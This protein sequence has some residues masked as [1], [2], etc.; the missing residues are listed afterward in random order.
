MVLA[1]LVALLV[2]T[3]VVITRNDLIFGGVGIWVLV[4]LLF[5]RLTASNVIME[6]VTTTILGI[7]VL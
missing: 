4:G 1:L 5:E 7:I 3:A 6:I 2:Y